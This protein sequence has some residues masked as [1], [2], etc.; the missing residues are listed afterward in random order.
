MKAS[1]WLKFLL[2]AAILLLSAGAF[3]PA[4]IGSRETDVADALRKLTDAPARMVWMR[5][6]SGGV[7]DVFGHESRFLLMGLDTEDAAG[8][9]TLLHEVSNYNKP[10]ITA[11]GD[12]VVFSDLPNNRIYAVNWDGTGLIELS[13]GRAVGLWTDPQS[14]IEWV[15]RLPVDAK[16]REVR[17]T[18]PLTRFQL[19]NP[20]IEEMVWDRTTVE[21]DNIQLSQDGRY[22]CGPFPWPDCGIVDVESNQ[23]IRLGKGC[24]PSMAPDNSYLMWIFDG[25]HRNLLFHTADNKRKWR[26]NVSEV[27]GVDGYEVYHP[28]WSNHDRFLCMTGPYHHGI[29]GGGGVVSVFAGRFNEQMT[30]VEAWV[31]V[32]DHG[33][34]DFYPD[35]WIQP[36]EGHYNPPDMESA[37]A[38]QAVARHDLLV[39]RARLLEKTP[40]P[41]MEEIAPYTRTLVVYRYAVEELKS[42]Q[43]NRPEILVAHW[44]LADGRITAPDVQT[45]ASVELRLEPYAAREELEGERL[46]MEL[47]DMSGPLFYDMES[48]P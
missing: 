17:A 8:E 31:R 4:G 14:G 39:V 47:S 44:G 6:V 46:T 27:P 38:G 32:T 9:R 19:S 16:Y 33:D 41:T 48:K 40:D 15:Y 18:K 11:R 2:P 30:G 1:A 10:L 28:R 13:K 3:L 25:P 34:A 29:K 12:R 20:L 36:G 7:K 37:G 42:G 22:I 24:W 26:V 5:Q 23:F 35:L 21:P 43:Y 45:G